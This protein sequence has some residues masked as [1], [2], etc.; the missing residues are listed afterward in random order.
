[1]RVKLREIEETRDVFYGTFRRTGRKGRGHH[2]ILLVDILDANMKLMTDHA[3]FNYTKGFQDLG[4]LVPGDQV[5]FRGRVKEYRKGSVRRGIK[6]QIDYK[7]S[8]PSQV[9]IYK[10]CETPP[11]SRNNIKLGDINNF[12]GSKDPPEL[13][14]VHE[15]ESETEY[16]EPSESYYDSSDSLEDLEESDCGPITQIIET[17]PQTEQ[18]LVP[19]PIKQ[20]PTAVSQQSIRDFFTKTTIKPTKRITQTKIDKFF[21]P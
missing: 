9:E 16:E 13:P 3:W 6:V 14:N 18:V 5:R 8:H 12:F 7:L 20:A 11:L 19:I 4:R 2:T 15:S 1:M 21:K 17:I 10:R